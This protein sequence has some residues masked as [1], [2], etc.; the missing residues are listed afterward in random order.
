MMKVINQ[1]FFMPT[2]YNILFSKVDTK[3]FSF[4]EITIKNVLYLLNNNSPELESKFD[5]Y[6]YIHKKL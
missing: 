4:N 1:T 2:N 5:I 3:I 6:I